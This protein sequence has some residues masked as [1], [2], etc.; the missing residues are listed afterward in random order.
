[1]PSSSVQLGQRL[2]VTEQ[3]VRQAISDSR[4]SCT[5]ISGLIDLTW[6][7]PLLLVAVIVAGMIGKGLKGV[8]IAVVVLAILGLVGIRRR[9]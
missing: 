7:F 2:T 1:M 8:V 9:R 5:A 3:Q 4:E 6:A